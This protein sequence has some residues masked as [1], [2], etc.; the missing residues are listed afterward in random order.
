MKLTTPQFL[1]SPTGG[2]LVIV[3]SCSS[4][5][6]RTGAQGPRFRDVASRYGSAKEAVESW[7][8]MLSNSV[9]SALPAKDFYVGNQWA[10]LREFARQESVNIWVASAGYGLVQGSAP[11]SDYSA[12]FSPG[13]PDSVQDPGSWGWE[14]NAAENWWRALSSWRGP[15][16]GDPRSLVAVTR[17]LRP[18]ALMTLLSTPYLKVLRED[19][20]AAREVLGADR[21]VILSPGGRQLDGFGESLVRIDGRLISELGGNMG[22]LAA[23]AASYIVAESGPGALSAPSARAVIDQVLARARPLR[24]FSRRVMSDDEVKSWIR[25]EFETHP[26]AAGVLLRRYRDAGYA[27]EQSRFRTLVESVREMGA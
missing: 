11:L 12:T 4:R 23:R 3:A 14:T 8:Q 9:A 24:R 20:L 18:S 19:L 1:P 16:S 2:G 13:H 6:R 7:T 27:C 26:A 15:S 25:Q 22:T 21:L 5:K 17:S 10:L